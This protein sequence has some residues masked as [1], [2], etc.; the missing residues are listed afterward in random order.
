MATLLDVLTRHQFY[1]EGVKAGQSLRFEAVLAKLREEIRMELL[2]A[3]FENIGELSRNKVTELVRTIRGLQRTIY[4]QYTEEVIRE[5]LLFLEYEADL[6]FDIFEDDD[7]GIPIFPWFIKR[8]NAEELQRLWSTIGNAPIP[9]NG[10]LML[11]FIQAFGTT[12]SRNVENAV[13]QEWANRSPRDEVLAR[14]VGTKKL[15][16]KDGMLH[17]LNNQNGAVVDTVFQHISAITQAAVGSLFR[18]QYRWVSII[19]NRTTEI[20]RSRNHNVYT[21]G[22]GPIPPAHIRCRSKI[23]PFNAANPLPED[24][25]PLYDWLKAQPPAVL[26]D[27]L[28]AEQAQAIIGG[29]AK[30]KDFVQFMGAKPISLK[31]FKAKRALIKAD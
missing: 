5:L 11:P 1:L 7:T 31:Q 27:L 16:N 30:A 20:C 26:Q 17:K 24:M 6:A 21:Y 12:A 9:A 14:I 4:S 23:V 3:D 15:G 10:V 29:T 25:P 2:R 28:N 18:R 22:Q 19:D 13:L 8:P